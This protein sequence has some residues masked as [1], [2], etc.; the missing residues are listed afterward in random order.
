MA[1]RWEH[2]IYTVENDGMGTI[3]VTAINAADSE[4]KVVMQFPH[5]TAI[6]LAEAMLLKAAYTEYQINEAVERITKF[7]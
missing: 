1:I 6:K 5:D 2:S 7:E 4:Q 3:T